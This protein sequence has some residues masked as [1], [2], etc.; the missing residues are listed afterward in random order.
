MTEQVRKS[1]AAWGAVG[2]GVGVLA[3]LVALPLAASGRL[4]DRLATHWHA[5]S[6]RP[7]GS[8]PLLAAALFPA[9]IWGVL[10]VVVVLTLRRAG[11]GGAVPGWAAAGLG[12][13]GVT[14]LGGQAS[15]VR[16]NLD[17]AD[18]H[19][20]GSVTSGVVGTLVVAAAVGAAGLLA[21]RR[22]P[23]EPRPAADG[24]TLDIPPGQRV[25][26]LA[27]TSNSWLQAIAALT[28]LLATTVFVSSL[29]GLTDLPFLLAATPF[30][31][32]SVLVLGCSSVQARVSEQGLDV[33]FGP[34]G[35][36]T[37]HWAAEDV[38]SAR[39]ESRTPAQVGGWGYRLSGLG[40]TVMLRGGE[41]LVIHPSKGREF[42]VSVDDAER[43]AA[44]LNSL[45]AR[46]TT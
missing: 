43:G 14:L 9:L 3:L 12:F 45:S 33:T 23:D 32:A 29:A 37:R 5:G 20:A 13:G 40:T 44:L 7:D 31:L 36:P 22:A 26:W 39:V 27:R 35:W 6:G 34:F 17:R 46:H 8:M 18:W 30:T 38:E 1:G 25:V 10:A 24:P 28:G 42:A 2:W 11:A 21:A 19:D 41:C 4:P 16:A 15:V